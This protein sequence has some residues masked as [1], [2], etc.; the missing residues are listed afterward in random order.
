MKSN[1][2][3]DARATPPSRPN[4]AAA[5]VSDM[6]TEVEIEWL[7]QKSREAEEYYRSLWGK[8]RP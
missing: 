2:K 5:A 8:D 1:E 3:S 6:L 4:S 7:R